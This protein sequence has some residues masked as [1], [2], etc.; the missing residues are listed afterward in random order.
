[1]AYMHHNTLLIYAAFV[2]CRDEFAY[3]ASDKLVYIRQ[4]SDKCSNMK[5]TGILQ[6]HEAD[7]TQVYLF[8][9]FI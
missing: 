3:A 8:G 7:V 1:M 9:Y 2:F 6:G 5:L 4:F